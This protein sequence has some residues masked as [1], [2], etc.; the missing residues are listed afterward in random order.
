MCGKESSHRDSPPNRLVCRR[1][2][3]NVLQFERIVLSRLLVWVVIEEVFVGRLVV[4]DIRA[5][6]LMDLRN[7]LD[8][9]LGSL[10]EVIW[11]LVA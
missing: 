4:S 3:E 8:I 2:P 10:I 9:C 1:V 5:A 11:C 6:E 7:V